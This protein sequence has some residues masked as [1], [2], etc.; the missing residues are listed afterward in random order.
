MSLKNSWQIPQ[1]TNETSF[2]FRNLSLLFLKPS[3]LFLKPSFLFLQSSVLFSK[4]S[5]RLTRGFLPPAH[6]SSLQ[7]MQNQNKQ[8]AK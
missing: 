5:F 4:F 2:F 1:D 3:F 6:P 8:P 7:N